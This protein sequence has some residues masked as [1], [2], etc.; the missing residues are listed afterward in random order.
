MNKREGGKERS[1]LALRIGA[2]AATVLA[3]GAVI[4]PRLI[5]SG[6][7]G[8][9]TGPAAAA[10]PGAPASELRQTT[11]S[12]L[13]APATTAVLPATT[14]PTTIPAP[15]TTVTTVPVFATTTA[16]A[17]GPSDESGVVDGGAVALTLAGLAD[18]ALGEARVGFFADDP[19]G[20]HFQV[21]NTG[22]EYLWGV[23][24]YLEL[25]GPV[26]CSARRLDVG[27][28]ADCWA[29]TTAQAGS[30]VADAW[31]T[32]WTRQRMLTDRLLAVVA[33]PGI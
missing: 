10:L 22:D 18:G 2:L 29:E 17:P 19:I 32:A 30:N 1:G 6:G 31:V 3:L 14:A 26:T 4:G 27:E 16:P 24:V 33:V 8:S 21:K 25:Y 28:F 9:Q 20:W 15:T 23:Y 11:T 13:V 5:S 12:A 7:G